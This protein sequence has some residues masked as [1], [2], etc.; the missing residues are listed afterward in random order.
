[1]HSLEGKVAIVTG[2]S[3][4]I[5]QA[6]ALLFAAQ[7]ARL[8][9]TARRAERLEKLVGEITQAGGEAVFHAGDIQEEACAEAL[10]D[11][12]LRTF[13]RLDIALNN[14]GTIGASKPITDLS[15][16]AWNKTL[17]TNLTSGFLG[18][19][20][21]IPAML[22]SGGGSL[23]FVSSFVGWSNG[24]PDMS[25]YAVSKAGLLGLTKAL[26]AEW[27]ARGIRVNGLL[28]GG[29]DTEM[30]IANAPG[31]GPEVLE[32]LNG[33]HALKRLADPKEI[34]RAALFLASDASSF[35]TGSSMFVDGGVSITK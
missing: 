30:N 28:P 16:E 8:V 17:A 22:K 12:A 34:A 18:A 7:G 1:M 13:G 32:Y 27:G 23:I 10:V 25:D 2:A 29:T 3:S 5:G 14:A 33:I 35:V 9:V 26:A 31:A 20:Y 11:M 4:G 24:F 15:L 19:K 6:A 21:Q